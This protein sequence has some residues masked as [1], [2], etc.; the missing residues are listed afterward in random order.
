M[1][2]KHCVSSCGEKNPD[3]LTTEEALNLCDKLADLGL[4][5][6]TLSGGEPLLRDDWLT[7]AEK[8]TNNNILVNVISNGWCID[9]ALLDDARRVGIINIGVRSGWA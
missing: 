3:E 5:R 4:S 7:I 6:L 9:K 1:R 8:L 2:C